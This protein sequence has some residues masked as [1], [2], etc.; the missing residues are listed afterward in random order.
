V[1]DAAAL[2]TRAFDHDPFNRR[3]LPDDD[4]RRRVRSARSRSWRGSASASLARG[5]VATCRAVAVDVTA[6][7]S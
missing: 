5:S 6:R 2:L 4:R 3:L 7:W 1:P